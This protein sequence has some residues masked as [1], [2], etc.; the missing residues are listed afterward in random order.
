MT[1]GVGAELSVADVLC[2]GGV[3]DGVADSAAVC[4][5]QVRVREDVE[6]QEGDWW[7]VDEQEGDVVELGVENV[8]LDDTVSV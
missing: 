4:V 7:R 5:D 2:D 8:P 3:G 6:D 1:D